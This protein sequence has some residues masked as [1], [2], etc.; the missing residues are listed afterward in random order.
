M[1]RMTGADAIINSLMQ[2]G[3]DTVFALPGGQLDN[4]FDAMYKKDDALQVIHSR[5][6]QGVAYMAFGYARSTGKVGVYSVV[7]GPGL[8]NSS[9]ALCT[10]WGNSTPVLCV[11]G[12]IPSTAIGKGYGD[13]HE[14]DD[15][16]GMISH[17]TKWSQRIDSPT[18]APS[19]IREA[20]K[21]L[22]TGRPRPVEVEMPMD[23]MGEV[24]DVALLDPL[25]E[26]EPTAIDSEKIAAAAKLLGKAKN[27]L[28]VI[29]GG[30]N[31]C[32]EGLLALA[33]ALQAPVV[34]KRNG[35]GVISFEHYLS[36]NAPL[37]HK[38]WAK[39]D[40]V[41]AIGTRLRECLTAWGKDDDMQLIRVDIDPVEI[42]RICVPE[43]GIVGDAARV[44]EALYDDVNRHNRKRASREQELT[45]LK[46]AF[47]AEVRENVAAQMA[48][49]DVIREVLP[50][51]GI[52][53][54]E[55]TQVGF[56]SWYGFPVY[57]PRQHI[58][59]SEMGTLGYGFA[60]ALGVAVANP[61]KKVIQISGDGGFM[62]NVQELC[63]AVQYQIPVV[64]VIFN[65][66]TYGNVQRQQDDWF[67][68]RRICSDLHNPDFAKLAEVFGATGMTADNPASLKTALEKAL[69]LNGPVLI[70]VP[71]TT[72]MPSPWPY[73]MLPQNRKAVCR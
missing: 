18:Q 54:D 4:L 16:L 67:G 31:H 32:A 58:T 44:I 41:L 40:V 2:Y 64:T 52:F 28:I 42:D 66:N 69:S 46:S 21:Q 70:E 13:L 11:A 15:Q 14:I 48:Y 33:Q 51:D 26:Y 60:T 63:T 45:E 53:V 56:T 57:Q 6:E 30:A 50:G 5:H 47:A 65:D 38:L 73:I 9:A 49:L 12:Q 17:L 61:G 20:F 43:V 68:G 55:I 22:N 35:K 59:C 23:T 62:F 3:V 39:T 8:L 7:P 24:A 71:V 1:N 29:G 34:A 19:V 37:G 72:R 27:P 36:M 10:A 25:T